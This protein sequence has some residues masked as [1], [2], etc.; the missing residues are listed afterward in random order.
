MPDQ[1][2]EAMMT[3]PT[4]SV[5]T[6]SF[7]SSKHI[8]LF[9]TTMC[10][11][12]ETIDC[13]WEVIIVD[14]GST[15]DTVVQCRSIIAAD[16][17][18]II[19]E[20][21]RNF[22]KEPA[23]VEGLRSAT[24]QLIFT[25]DSDLEEPP[26]TL[27]RMLEVMR[28]DGVPIDVVYGVRAK[29]EGSLQHTIGG[30]MFARIFNLLS[31]VK[32]PVDLLPIRL[33]TRRYVDAVLMHRE[34]A[35]AL[36]GVFMSAGFEQRPLM[37]EKNYKGYSSYTF[38]R[39]VALALRYVMV[40]SSKPALLITSLGL[41]MVLVAGS[42]AV[43][44][45]GVHFLAQEP[46]PAWTTVVVLM[47][48]F[49]GL[50]LTSVGICAAYLAYIFQEVKQ[51][52]TAIVKAVYGAHHLEPAPVQVPRLKVDRLSQTL[53]QE[54]SRKCGGISQGAAADTTVSQPVPVERK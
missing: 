22:G 47:A 45:L 53:V 23:L 19:L 50:L 49:N 27:L 21:S 37:V 54:S 8:A 16:P 2:D 14:D 18:L 41:G 43:Y 35:L 9:C 30:F 42:Y 48:L 1:A 44:A 46:L 32:I 33:M 15:D 17:R 13:T 11:V 25:L 28:S 10:E 12:L 26:S 40:F 52:P 38:S 39:R 5:V 4:I 34:R 20:L 3:G 36:V 29:R 51:R 7:N 31:D 6:T 24:G